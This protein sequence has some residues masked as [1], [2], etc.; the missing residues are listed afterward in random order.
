MTISQY[1]DKQLKQTLAKMLPEI[2]YWDKC[3]ELLRYPDNN[4]QNGTKVLD[5]ELL[6]LCWLMEKPMCIDEWIA[7]LQVLIGFTEPGKE[8]AYKS[9]TCHSSWQQRTMALV[10]TKGIEIV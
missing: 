2:V 4:E 6:H 9:F 3:C 8:Q 1:T 5:T 10:K 7:Y